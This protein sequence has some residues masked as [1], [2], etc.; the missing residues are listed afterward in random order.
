MEIKEISL[1]N[2]TNYEKEKCFFK[3]GINIIVGD[4]AQGKSNILNSIYFLGTEST[5]NNQKDKD[6]VKW[7]KDYFKVFG[8]F[9]NREGISEV[10]IKFEK[11][12]KKL[13]LNRY[14][15]EKI[16]DFLGYFISVYFCPEDLYIVKGD[17]SLRR[18]YLDNELSQTDRNYYL[19]LNKYKKILDQ[20]NNLLKKAKFNKKSL[21]TIDIWEENLSL[22]GTKIL[23]KRIEMF[24]VLKK[25]AQ[26]A[27]FKISEGKENLFLKY[28]SHLPTNLLE[29]DQIYSFQSLYLKSLKE[30]RNDDIEKG[31]TSIGPHRD[32]LEILINEKS[33]K[34]FGSQGQQR[35]AALSLKLAEVEYIKKVKGEYPVFLLDDVLSELDKKRKNKLL[36]SISQLQTIITTTDL[37]DIEEDIKENSKII[38][39]SNG[40]LRE[41]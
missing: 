1:E 27:H 41:G 29:T 34:K 21:D 35:T 39:V 24:G 20:R 23:E 40:E 37:N 38:Y 3:E 36:E 19:Y 28:I 2:F 18:K 13:Y 25:L 7:G 30:K 11:N 9:K 16:K 6:I 15:I 33:V 14:E 32:D 12:K 22:Y 4:N 8:T 26:E 10:L 17:P 31:Y 5:P